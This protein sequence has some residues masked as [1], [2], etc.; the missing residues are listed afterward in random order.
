VL[1]LWRRLVVGWSE[2]VCFGGRAASG[3]GSGAEPADSGVGS[4]KGMKVNDRG[5]IPSEV[6]DAYHQAS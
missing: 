2:G 3:G 5:R 1:T 6:V 4:G